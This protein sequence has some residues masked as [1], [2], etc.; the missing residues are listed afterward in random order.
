MTSW[1]ETTKCN[2]TGYLF[3]ENFVCLYECV[4]KTPRH[5]CHVDDI[6]F[7]FN[8]ATFYLFLM[9]DYVYELNIL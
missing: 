3:G 8:R 7:L 9:P 5:I 6:L 2:R 4:L 1:E